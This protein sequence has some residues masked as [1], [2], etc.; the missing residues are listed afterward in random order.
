MS[1]PAG[2]DVCVVADADD[3]HAE[4]VLAELRDAGLVAIRFNLGDLRSLTSVSSTGAFD[5]D[6]NGVWHRIG[7]STT[8]WWRRMG[9]ICV[10]GLDQQEASLV[11][12]EGPFALTGALEGAGVRWADDPFDVDRAERKQFQLATASALGIPTPGWAVTNVPSI[13]RTVGPGRRVGKAL[14]P[15]WGIAPFVAEVDDDDLASVAGA[16]VLVQELV[17]ATADLRVVVVGDQAWIWERQRE[18]ATL[19]WRAVDPSGAGFS[20]RSDEQLGQGAVGLTAALRLTIA[21]QDWLDTPKGPVFLEVNPQGAWS[22]LVGA[23]EN[24]GPAIARHLAPLEATDNGKWPRVRRRVLNDFYS[25]KK[26]PP[27]D[28][29]VAP[30]TQTPSWVAAAAARPEALDL[31]RRSRESAEEGAK[32]AEEKA[33]RQ[34]QLALGL[35]TITI[36]LTGY[37][38]RQ[39]A[40][41][42]WIYMPLAIPALAAL[43]FLIVAAFEAAQVDRVGVYTKPHPADLADLGGRSTAAA[44]LAGEVRGEYLAR[45]TSTNKHTD[46]MQARAWY[47]RGLATALLAGLVA[48]ITLALTA[49]A[50]VT[51][52]PST[53]VPASS[54]P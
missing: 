20:P 12:D 46:L 51:V 32:R 34:V 24:V 30:T 33:T 47:T 18:P 52:T 4:V 23:D 5:L 10:D 6:V 49:D 26:A 42:G 25:E 31:G 11:C 28:G 40:V 43:T 9:T 8:V 19:D 1:E 48:A 29:I 37:Q 22:F 7:S 41:H 53:S 38:L 2:V 13:A 54:R 14:S 17:D 45:W 50:K 44:I 15:G 36:A 3:P 35:I 39:A 27:D 16:P 21:V